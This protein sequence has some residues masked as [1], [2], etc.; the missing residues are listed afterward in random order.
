[1]LGS[2][3]QVVLS[4]VRPMQQCIF[5][6]SKIFQIDRTCSEKP[7][8]TN[9]GPRTVKK[10][11]K[12]V[13]NKPFFASEITKINREVGQKGLELTIDRLT[14]KQHALLCTPVSL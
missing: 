5:P 9:F 2:I 7:C 13:D 4:D 11:S 10:S 8:S 14:A 1:M 6:S 12:T 3:P